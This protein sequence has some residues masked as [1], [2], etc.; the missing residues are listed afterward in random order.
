MQ[1]YKGKNNVYVLVVFGGPF[2][3]LWNPTWVNLH[4]S[5]PPTA[6]ASTDEN[7]LSFG[8]HTW[9]CS[10]VIPG[11]VLWG[12]IL[13]AEDSAGVGQM[14]GKC[15]ITYTITLALGRKQFKM[16]HLNGG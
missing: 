13:K 10:G 15:S 2:M 3:V 5:S 6:E 9:H 4:A 11:S 1:F 8:G 7:T 16:Q 12:P 14:Q